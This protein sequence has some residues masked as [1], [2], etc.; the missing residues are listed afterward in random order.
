M[1]RF[2]AAGALLPVL[3]T[4]GC[5]QRGLVSGPPS[6]P[7]AGTWL[8]VGAAASAAACVLA[9]LIVLPAS[10]PGGCAF[11]ARLLALQA[12]AVVVGGAVLVGGALRGATLV[13]RADGAEQAASLLQL[14]GLDGR[15]P[16]FFHLVAGLTVVLGGLLVAVLVLAARFAADVDP[17]ERRLAC[18]LLA[19]EALVAAVAVVRGLG[20]HLGLP[21]ALTAAFLPPLVVAIVKCRPARE[22]GEQELGYNGT[23][24]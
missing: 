21:F 23:H 2:Q 4:S 24:G 10:R 8:L 19:V 9:A 6:P 3:L 12:G 18:C 7:G 1:N 13:E 17:V 14:G 16:G 5:A 22:A 20:G 11:A 15:D